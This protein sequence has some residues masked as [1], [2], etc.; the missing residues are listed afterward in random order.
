MFENKKILVLGAARSGI[1]CSKILAKLNCEVI[2]NDISDE[3]L[4]NKEQINELEQSLI[5]FQTC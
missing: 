5:A 4:L 3:S 1:A 2:L